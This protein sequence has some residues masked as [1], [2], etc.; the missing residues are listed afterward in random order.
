MWCWCFLFDQHESCRAQ[1]CRCGMCVVRKPI[2]GLRGSFKTSPSTNSQFSSSEFN[3]PRNLYKCLFHLYP[4]PHTWMYLQMQDRA[5]MHFI[6]YLLIYFCILATANYASPLG[7]VV[8]QFRLS[9]SAQKL[10]LLCIP[11]RSCSDS[12]WLLLKASGGLLTVHFESSPM[13]NNGKPPPNLQ[14][15]LWPKGKGAHTDVKEEGKRNENMFEN[16][17][18]WER[19]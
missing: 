7:A 3:L 15:F 11:L 5:Y 1:K 8:P 4:F 2:I 10:E 14:V 9:I 12:L 18:A 13:N 6:E 19:T 16:G 17:V